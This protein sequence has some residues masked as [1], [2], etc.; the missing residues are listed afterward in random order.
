MPAYIIANVNITDPETY[1]EYM[2]LVPP[3]LDKF[4]GKPVVRGGHAE[5]LEGEWQ[6]SRVSVLEFE[7]FDH[8]MQ[9]WNSED[10]AD[11]KAM[12]QRSSNTQMIVVE[13]T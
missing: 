2:K 1:Q 3:T 7:S 13:G 9:W 4:G 8:A 5:N 12:R 6:P 11:A 10:Y